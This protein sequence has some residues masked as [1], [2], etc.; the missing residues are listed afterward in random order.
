MRDRTQGVRGQ[1]LPLVALQLWVIAAVVIALAMLGQRTVTRTRAQVVADAA[2]LAA[3]NGGDPGA[4]VAGSG[5]SIN[6]SEVAGAIDVVVSADDVAAAAR[7]ERPVSG[8]TAGLDPRLI[9]AIG[10]AEGLL[11]EPV[12]IVSGLRSRADQERLWANRHTNPYPVAEPGTSMHE[13]GLAID[14]PLTFAPRL[15]SVGPAVG[16]CR[17]LPSTDPVHF[18]LCDP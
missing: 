5:L 18:V 12:P 3:A 16:L 2:A 8:A 7:A 4:V 6:R 14:V 1:S 10:L 13:R 17:P 9:A 11:G 15:A